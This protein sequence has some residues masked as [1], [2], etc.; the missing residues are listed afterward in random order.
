MKEYRKLKN[1]ILEIKDT[2]KGLVLTHTYNDLE[3]HSANSTTPE[4]KAI[5][6]ENLAQASALGVTPFDYATYFVPS[7]AEWA[8]DNNV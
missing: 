5:A 6:E 4:K 8:E 1:N 7:I 2:S 3:A